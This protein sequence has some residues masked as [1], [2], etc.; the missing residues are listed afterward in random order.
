MLQGLLFCAALFAIQYPAAPE[1]PQVSDPK[2]EGSTRPGARSK[3]QRA[4][5]VAL[6]AVRIKLHLGD[7]SA[8]VAETQIPATYSFTHKKGVIQ[9]SQT[10]R[11]EDIREL[12]VESYRSRKV[13]TTAEGDVYE[14]EP[15]TVR[16]ELKDGQVFKLGYLF[17]ELRML[18][19]K[20]ADGA[21]SV[22][23]YFADTWKNA[24]WSERPSAP[25][26]ARDGQSLVTRTAHP[27]AY[28]RLE[29]F[30]PVEKAPAAGEAR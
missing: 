16:I 7:K 14:F 21:F 28:T 29:Y 12:A 9:Y 2:V 23:A 5:K 26:K 17:K 25:E 13:A 18:K 3:A 22:F 30:E 10:I 24:A 20:N 6:V 27:A 8:L 19:A 1:L 11:A 15:A 4:E